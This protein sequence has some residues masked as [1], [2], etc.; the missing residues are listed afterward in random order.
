MIF[1][2]GGSTSVDGFAELYLCV[3]PPLKLANPAVSGVVRRNWEGR[4]GLLSE[5]KET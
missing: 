1:M 5:A 3:A 2:D 4:S